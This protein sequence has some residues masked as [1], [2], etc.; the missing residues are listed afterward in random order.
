MVLLINVLPLV[1]D[2]TEALLAPPAGGPMC[3]QGMDTAAFLQ[4]LS[5]CLES[6]T[7]SLPR[8]RAA[9]SSFNQENYD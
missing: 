4:F 1:V 9:D 7:A 2:A 3:E 6:S 8:R 5:F